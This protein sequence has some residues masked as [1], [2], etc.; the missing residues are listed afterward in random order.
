MN[1][2]FPP[3]DG[4][5]ALVHEGR[6]WLIGG[7][8]RDTRY[9]PRVCANDVWCSA[10]GR[11]WHC[12]KANTFLDERFDGSCD[13]EGRHCA[14]YAVHRGRMWILGGDMNQGHFQNDIWSSADGG[15]WDRVQAP[16]GLPWAN[17]AHH[18][19]AV[20]RDQIWVMGGQTNGG[21]VPGVVD[22]F[23]DDLWTTSDGIEWSR[24]EP[25]GT[26]WSPRGMIGNQAVLHDRV[27]ILGGGTY[28]TPDHPARQYHNDVW[29]SPDG[30]HW[31][32]HL[33]HAPWAPRQY[34]EVAAFDGRLWV[35]EGWDGRQNRRDVWYSDDGNDWHELPDTPWAPRHA[36]SVFV[37]D[38]ALWMVT[39]NNMQ[40]DVWRLERA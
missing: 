16:D 24:I 4:A 36:A 29:S 17:R 2:A 35:L 6:M 33:E 18:I 22:A 9:F 38:D 5:G 23:H 13:W 12:V 10:D 34:H 14:G 26:R 25:H 30:V 27:W 3:R 32:R 11:D 8:S 1:A 7:W 21:F 28:D 40:S 15:R 37:F 19:C 39:G 31:T 20:H